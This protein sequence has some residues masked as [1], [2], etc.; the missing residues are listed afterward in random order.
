M[1][2]IHQFIDFLQNSLELKIKYTILTIL[3]TIHLQQISRS[4]KPNWSF[5]ED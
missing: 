3:L 1:K 2:F 5:I 4:N